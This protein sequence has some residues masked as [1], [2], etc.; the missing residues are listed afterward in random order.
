MLTYDEPIRLSRDDQVLLE[1]G[2]SVMFQQCC[3]CG[4]THRIDFEGNKGDLWLRFESIGKQFPSDWEFK[5]VV[6]E[7]GNEST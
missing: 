4:L 7:N 5:T 6:R 3:D 1:A 2:Q